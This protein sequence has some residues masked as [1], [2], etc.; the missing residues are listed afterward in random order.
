MKKI[1]ILISALLF[2]LV[3]LAEGQEKRDFWT[4]GIGKLLKSADDFVKEMEH[5]GFDTTYIEVPER[6][7]MIYIGGYGSVQQYD[8]YF[9]V[10]LEKA[11]LPQFM[12]S[13]VPSNMSD[14]M[15]IE[16]HFRATRADLAIG[17]DWRGIALELPIPVSNKYS[18]SY[19]L[20]KN[21]TQW[22]F[23]VRYKS[24]NNVSGTID[25]SF[26]Q[27]T[28]IMT[29]N[30]INDIATYGEMVGNNDPVQ[31]VRRDIENGTMDLKTFYAEGY[32]VFN[33]RK[34]SLAAGLYGD[35]IQ[36][37]SA[38]SLIAMANYFQ[39]H[40]GC[41]NMMEAERDIF[42]NQIASVGM[43]YGYNISMM[44]GR[45]CLHASLIPMFSLYNHI[46]H[47]Q[48]NPSR[49]TLSTEL[50][51]EYVDAFKDMTYQYYRHY[52]DAVDVARD[53]GFKI[54]GFAR[55]AANYSFDRFILTALIN[56]RQYLFSSSSGMKINNQEGDLQINLGYRF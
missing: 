38:G 21:G 13:Y 27:A 17:I 26:S 56:Y 1:S 20:A 47:T 40:L 45:L 51:D 4:H 18:R 3:T 36:K 2:S 11:D 6:D 30:F 15:H 9:P 41:N 37:R 53:S 22:G 44:G 39:S 46:I 49:E 29:N 25:D 33:H 8:L 14:L 35:M 19:G 10:M 32:Y 50:S 43:G 31:T 16:P 52:Y 55:L 24:V 5:S 23:R 28:S 42:R 48:R 7:R 34:F 54:H 12:Q